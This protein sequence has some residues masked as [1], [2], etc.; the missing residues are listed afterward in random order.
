LVISFCG[1]DF[2]L[3]RYDTSS[4]GKW[5]PVFDGNVMALS[6]YSRTVFLKR[7]P[8]ARYP[9]LASIIPGRKR[10]SWKLSF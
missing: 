6:V 8:A 9:A 1:E 7:R 5:I 4:A 10:F 3:L 2:I